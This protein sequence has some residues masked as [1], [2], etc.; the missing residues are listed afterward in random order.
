MAST[1]RRYQ[2]GS[3]QA[4]AKMH[5]SVD[6]VKKN[7]GLAQDASSSLSKIVGRAQTLASI[8]INLGG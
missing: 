6:L 4:V 7:V 5:E 8:G 1:F 3:K 2:A